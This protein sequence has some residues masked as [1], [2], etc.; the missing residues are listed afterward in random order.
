MDIGAGLGAP[1][2]ATHTREIERELGGDLWSLVCAVGT[3]LAAATPLAGDNYPG[4]RP[5]AFRLRFADGRVLKGRRV[6]TPAQAEAVEYISRCLGHR[7]LPRMLARRGRAF[8]TEWIEGRP[9]SAER[10]DRQVL[11]RCGALQGWVHS[12][13][14]PAGNPLPASGTIESW[15]ASAE[16]G[17]RALVE[18]AVLDD[19]VARNAAE[20]AEAY[21]PRSC[22]WV[23]AY[24]DFCADNIVVQPSGEVCLVDNE[25]LSIQ[26]CDYDLGRTWYRWPMQRS[27]R[28]AFLNGYCDH[29]RVADSLAHFPFWAIAAVV[30]GALFR[31]GKG[32]A[33]AAAV[34][35]QRLRALVRDMEHG[36]AAEDAVFRS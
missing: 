8:L 11:Q 20:I 30:D 23:F 1:A 17:L 24:V 10:C 26:P 16:R 7:G 34:P 36:V 12:Q 27:D 5:N 29:R 2:R 32:G 3:Q 19:G 25:T 35:V 6:D 33:A 4:Y 28:E 14:V 15:R 9:L 22:A 31:V 21:A 13:A 18:Q